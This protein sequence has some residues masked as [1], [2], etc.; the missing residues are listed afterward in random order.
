MAI[1]S[2]VN[3]MGTMVLPFLSVYLSTVRGFTLQETGLIASAFGFGSFAG[4]WLGGKVINWVGPLWV[5]KGSMFLGGVFLVSIQWANGFYSTYTLIFMASIFGEAYRPALMTAL[6]GYVPPTETGRSMSLIR[7]AINLGFTAA[8]AI[9]GFVAATIGYQWLF[10]IDGSTCLLAA[11]YF[12]WATTKYKYNTNAAQKDNQTSHIT[13]PPYRNRLY[14]LFLLAAVFGGFTFM[15]WFQSVPVFIKTVWQYD[16]RYIGLLMALSSVVI[17]I[18]EMPAIHYLEQQN[19]KGKALLAG[20]ALMAG[21]FLILLFPASYLTGIAM[22]LVFTFGEALYL[23]LV[24]TL[25][26]NTSPV[27]RKGDY[28]A[29]YW[30]AWSV[31][32]IIA[33]TAGLTIASVA[34]FSVFWMGLAGTTGISMVL[35]WIYMRKQQFQ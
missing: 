28:M 35:M 7:L 10:W 11:F 19:L 30:M 32:N 5:I 9:G 15:Q 12:H 2:F 6:S 8:P 13:P 18:F 29:W 17:I 3:R 24:N 34:G 26:I 25:A 4:A 1:L 22:M 16:E 21:G 31:V 33:P 23:P 14:L 27:S 20:L